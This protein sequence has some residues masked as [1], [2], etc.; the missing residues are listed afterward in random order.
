MRDRPVIVA[1]LLLFLGLVGFPVWHGLMR[2]TPPTA[3]AI[4][5]PVAQKQCVAP[6]AYMRTSHMRLLID[7]R[8]QVVRD[9]QRQF[10]AFNGKIYDKSLT[11]TCLAQ[12]HG[13]KAEFCDRCHKYAGVS[14]PYCWDCH[15]N[16]QQLLAER[17]LAP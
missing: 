12:C 13:N 6:P 5:L 9:D 3:P 10:R 2:K 16:A 8:E 11:K 1:G 14:G 17:R 4:Q 15:N 7:W